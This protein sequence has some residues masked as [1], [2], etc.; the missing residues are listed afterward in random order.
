MIVT[1]NQPRCLRARVTVFPGDDVIVRRDAEQIG[2]STI[3]FVIRTSACDA[4]RTGDCD[5]VLRVT[6]GSG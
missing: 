6:S 4:E 1:L 5:P 3:A 2:V